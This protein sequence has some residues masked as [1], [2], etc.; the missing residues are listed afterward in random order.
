VVNDV[1]VV[2]INEASF[3]QLPEPFALWHEHLGKLMQAMVIA[4]PSVLG[5]DVVL[6]DRSFQFLSPTYDRS[7]LQGLLAL[8]TAQIPVVLGQSLDDEGIPSHIYPPYIALAGNHGLASVM[9]CADSDGVV[10][11]AGSHTCNRNDGTETL[12]EAMAWHL[13]IETGH[14][15]QINYRIGNTFNYVPFG[16]VLDWL[17]KGDATNL[18]E[19]FGGHPVLLGVTTPYDDRVRVSVPLAAWEPQSRNISGVLVHAQSLRSLIDGGLVHELPRSLIVFVCVLG[20]LFWFGHT[21]WFKLIL[22]SGMSVAI[23]IASSCLYCSGYYLPAASV[24]LCMLL[25]ASIRMAWDGWNHAR[26]KSMLKHSFGSYVSPEI[27]KHI[28][29]GDIKPGL[30][31]ERRKVC[32]LFSDVRDF[33]TRSES[34]SPEELIKLLNR[35]F[36]Q[37]TLAIHNNGGTLDKFIGDGI[38]AFFGA[39]QKLDDPVQRALS[40][41]REMMERLHELNTQLASEGVPPIRIGIGLHYGE[42]VIGH[43]GSETRHEYTAIG[44]VVNLAARLEG[45]SKEV[46]FPIVCSA[47]VAAHVKSNIQLQEIGERAIKGRAAECVFGWNPA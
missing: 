20:S 23:Y 19:T 11:M 6:P 39:P 14:Q 36:S 17:E 10:R 26:E 44:D 12:S 13:G 34:M 24:I 4:K 25:A 5:L 9:V 38:M 32:V 46:G 42:A 16:K 47:S 2:G 22:L 3:K 45:L 40:A 21:T 31:G 37:M 35:Y 33:T 27:L 41:S 43:V 7:L 8:R 15:G 30:G 28:V 18:R 29:S 1:V